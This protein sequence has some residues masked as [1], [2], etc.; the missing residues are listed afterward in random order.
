MDHASARKLI[1]LNTTFYQQHAA[2]FS[3]TSQAPLTG[4]NR[5]LPLLHDRFCDEPETLLLSS[6]HHYVSCNRQLRC[7]RHAGA[8]RAPPMLVTIPEVRRPF[9]TARAAGRWAAPHYLRTLRAR[10][11]L[12]VPAPCSQLRAARRGASHAACAPRAARHRRRVI[13]AVHE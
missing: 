13:L 4:W 5:M 9:C 8:P 6:H 7:I 10:M 1:A 2:Y 12:W 11:Q 3:A